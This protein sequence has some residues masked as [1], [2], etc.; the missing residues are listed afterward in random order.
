MI[1][2]TKRHMLAVEK[3]GVPTVANPLKEGAMRLA[4]QPLLVAGI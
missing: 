1:V 2:E 4:I 3:D